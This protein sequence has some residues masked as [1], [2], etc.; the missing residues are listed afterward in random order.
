MIGPMHPEVGR[1]LQGARR[2]DLDRALK[3][4]RRATRRR[5]REER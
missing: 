5:P 2:D 4:C 1:A 3:G